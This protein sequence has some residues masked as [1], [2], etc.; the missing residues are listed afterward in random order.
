MWWYAQ[1]HKN[2]V[3]LNWLLFWLLNRNYNW[4]KNAML[5]TSYIYLYFYLINFK[6]KCM[7]NWIIKF[8]IYIFQYTGINIKWIFLFY[9]TY[10]FTLLHYV[11]LSHTFRYGHERLFSCTCIHAFQASASCKL[12]HVTQA[13][14]KAVSV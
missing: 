14:P 4:K 11:S 5:Y 13:V 6:T 8:K 10:A 7:Q 1:Y 3:T 12:H 9:I 2:E